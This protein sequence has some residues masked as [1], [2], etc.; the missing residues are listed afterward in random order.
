MKENKLQKKLSSGLATAAIQEKFSRSSVV[1]YS[2]TDQVTEM[3]REMIFK[4]GLHPG[5][6]LNEVQLSEALK[7]SRSPIREAIQ[8]LANEGLVVLVHRKGAYI[9]KLT[10]KEV[11]DLF[12]VRIA[13]ETKAA[14]LAAERASGS[15][16]NEIGSFLE[17]TRSALST[18]AYD[19]YP[20]DFDFHLQIASLTQNAYLEEKIQEINAKLM[21][22]R[23]LSGSETRRAWEAFEEHNEVFKYIKNREPK[24][25]SMAMEEHFLRGRDTIL[26]ILAG[27]TC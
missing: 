6:R 26:R 7:I 27:E 23:Y 17:R 20:L 8:R 13:L 12:E 19:R 3:I 24:L 9:K 25:A 11:R 5:E 10:E 16:L 4:G 1:F 14:Y 18:K 22:V 15:Q 21:L 2:V